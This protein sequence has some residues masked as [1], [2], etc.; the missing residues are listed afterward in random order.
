[1]V[2]N[3]YGGTIKDGIAA[4]NG[5][6]I[7]GAAKTEIHIF[8]GATILN[9]TATAGGNIYAVSP[10]VTMDGGLLSGGKAE[11]GGNIAFSGDVNVELTNGT[12]E[13]GTAT[14]CG[15][16]VFIQNIG[17][18]TF[19]DMTITQ[20]S[21]GND[22]GNIYIY[23]N[24]YGDMYL[25]STTPYVTLN[26]TLVTAGE[27]KHLGGGI[28]NMHGKLTI[29]GNSKIVNNTGSNLYLDAGQI[30]HLQDMTADAAIGITMGVAGKIT[31]DTAFASNIVSDNSACSVTTVGNSVILLPETAP[32]VPDLN[33]YSVGWHRDI[34]TSPFPVPLDGMGKNVDRMNTYKV[35]T[36]LTA[37]LVVIADETGLENAVLMCTMDTIVI[38]AE[39]SDA[40]AAVISDATGIPAN[41]I[42]IGGTHTHAA[43]S[44]DENHASTKEY[45]QWL[46]PLM[47]QYAVKAVE[48]LAPVDT[49]QM[50]RTNADGMTRVRRFVDA[51]GNA[52]STVDGNVPD[53]AVPETDPDTELQAIRFNR[54]GKDDVILVNFQSHPGHDASSSN[55]NVSAEM[56][57]AFR[58]SV[59]AQLPGTVCGLFLGACGNQQRTSTT[60]YVSADGQT[61]NLTKKAEYGAA[62]AAHLIKAFENPTQINTG[63]VTIRVANY[64]FNAEDW[65]EDAFTGDRTL[66][67]MLNAVAIG[68][69]AF[70]T[71]PYEM[72]HENG[73][74]V[75]DFVYENDLFKLA[76]VITNTN[77]SNKYIAS[78]L[79]FQNDETDGKLTS[80]GVKSTRFN[81]GIAE[82]LVSCHAQLLAQLSGKDIEAPDF[83]EEVKNAK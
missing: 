47:A 41:H 33:A 27:A 26:N 11:N 1:M 23:R 34:V 2:L 49:T 31:E 65:Y 43:V 10:T 67:L 62:L 32:N 81:K 75:K 6:N 35:L 74:M 25:K 44:I 51:D 58:E 64:A 53:G 76:F 46:Y 56:W 80:F 50:I 66:P 38:P 9:G 13:G 52:Y 4:A 8:E 40:I 37:S 60:A 42:F 82:A 16:N 20:G 68:D 72:F 36:E 79:A 54:S 39:F 24:M 22:G 7:Y 77:G 45:L 55:G 48:D 28:Y 59:E 29:T 71:A 70:I 73:E 18:F 21:A 14:A 3:I 12:I 15:G 57:G 17:S 19:S 5:G 83:L 30:V 69:F 63:D 78:Y 61:Y